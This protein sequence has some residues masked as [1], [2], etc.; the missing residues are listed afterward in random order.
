MS[1]SKILISSDFKVNT[2]V[3]F[4]KNPTTCIPVTIT[5]IGKTKFTIDIGGGKFCEFR[6]G[7]QNVFLIAP[8]ATAA[9]KPAT[10]GTFMSIENIEPDVRPTTPII[11]DSLEEL[12]VQPI[13]FG[14]TVG[15]FVSFQKNPTTCVTV[16]ISKV[17]KTKFTINI[18]G[19]KFC[20]FPYGVPQVFHDCSAL[21]VKSEI[22][23]SERR[24]VTPDMIPGTFVSF[25]KNLTTCVTA[26]VLKCRKVN[27]DI[28]IGD[29]KTCTFPYSTPKVFVQQTSF[30]DDM[31][32]VD[33]DD[34]LLQDEEDRREWCAFIKV[35]ESEDFDYAAM[36]DHSLQEDGM[37]EEDLH[38]Y[39]MALEGNL[40]NQAQFEL[41]EHVC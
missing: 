35:M 39:N 6:Y 24:P 28:N 20:E 23:L 12:D 30:S 29:G 34:T 2:V 21:D 3:S 8:E 5:K 38:E 14:I 26:T 37:T 32:I 25:Q 4:Q 17:T 27:F 31:S 13:T 1:V 36:Q 16:V 40:D 11:S 41:G 22:P 7:V 15:T 33:A 10:E 19:G 9:M 18:G